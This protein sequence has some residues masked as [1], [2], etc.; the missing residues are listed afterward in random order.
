MELNDKW[1]RH[2]HVWIRINR[3]MWDVAQ[4]RGGF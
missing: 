4:C 3:D 2:V 1:D